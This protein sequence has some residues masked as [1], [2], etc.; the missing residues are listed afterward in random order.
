MGNYNSDQ[1]NARFYGLKLSKNTD[2]DLIRYLDSQE[3]IQGYLK[4]LIRNDMMKG[5]KT[6][7]TQE[8][9]DKLPYNVR[10]GVLN[11]YESGYDYS[12]D[13]DVWDG[14][15]DDEYCTL[16]DLKKGCQIYDALQK[17]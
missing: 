10:E 6:M 12:D 7:Y 3:S 8:D 13:S 4:Q 11:F 17:G 2:A 16:A 15:E 5:E 1:K 9:F 14:R